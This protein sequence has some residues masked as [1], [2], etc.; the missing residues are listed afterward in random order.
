MNRSESKQKRD[1]D[2]FDLL[3]KETIK[4]FYQDH[5]IVET[6]NEFHIGRK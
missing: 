6:M 1:K 4:K 3:D 2:R 5:T